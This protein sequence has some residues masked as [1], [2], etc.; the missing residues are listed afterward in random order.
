MQIQSQALDRI[1]T[2]SISGERLATLFEGMAT[3]TNK[4][5]GVTTTYTIDYENPEEEKDAETWIP[6]IILVL[7]PPM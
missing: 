5:G 3:E 1:R 4:S 6:Q 7:R 2:A